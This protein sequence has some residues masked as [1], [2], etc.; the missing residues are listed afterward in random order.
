M[1][2]MFSF[3]RHPSPEV[4]VEELDVLRRDGSVRVLDVREDWEFVRGHVPGAIHVPLG[5]LA[6]RVEQLPRDRRILVICAS[7]HRS[8]SAADLLLGRGFEGA[9][10]VRG[11]TG[12]WARAGGR[13]E[14][15]PA[16]AA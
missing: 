16:G 15:G 1:R 2:P 11:G 9:A 14:Q 7:G 3:L 4:S 13:L 12:A 10:S 8:R 6:G 5:Q